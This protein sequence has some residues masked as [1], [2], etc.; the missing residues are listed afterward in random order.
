M[1]E[2]DA[3]WEELE[4]WK[5]RRGKEFVDKLVRLTDQFSADQPQHF[6]PNNRTHLQRAR[7]TKHL[8]NCSYVRVQPVFDSYFVELTGLSKCGVHTLPQHLGMSVLEAFG[9][10]VLIQSY[11]DADLEEE[12]GLL[13]RLLA[14]EA[15]YQQK[16]AVLAGIK[17][18]TSQERQALRDECALYEAACHPWR[19]WAAAKQARNTL[20]DEMGGLVTAVFKGRKKLEVLRREVVTMDKELSRSKKLKQES[21]ALRRSVLAALA[22]NAGVP[23]APTRFK[24]VFRMLLDRAKQGQSL[25]NESAYGYGQARAEVDAATVLLECLRKLKAKRETDIGVGI[26][27]FYD[28][29]DP[30]IANQEE[31]ELSAQLGA[32]MVKD[33]AEELKSEVAFGI[34]E[35]L[36]NFRFVTTKHLQ[37]LRL[38][39]SQ[40]EALAALRGVLS[41]QIQELEAKAP[42]PQHT[43]LLAIL[44]KNLEILW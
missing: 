1:P 10:W 4:A 13:A 5:K 39:M 2:T 32:L 34:K 24:D 11:L 21:A 31:L 28:V 18:P 20:G 36:I 7:R 41:Q 42:I 29:Q 8:Y 3:D 23:S 43:D 15:A 40:A 30:A 33:F 37:R 44:K 35:S 6:D 38:H 26:Q 17:I 12:D 9:D 27:Y 25:I 19:N 22:E 16:R 14:D